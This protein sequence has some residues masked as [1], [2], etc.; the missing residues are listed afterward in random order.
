MLE[1]EKQ[2]RLDAD[3]KLAS[4]KQLIEKERLE[5]DGK[6]AEAEKEIARLNA[7]VKDAEERALDIQDEAKIIETAKLA[8]LIRFKGLDDKGVN[9]YIDWF[10]KLDCIATLEALATGS[11][12]N[13]S[14]LSTAESPNT[15]GQ[16]EDA[17]PGEKDK[18]AG[19]D[20]S[21]VS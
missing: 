17:A 5:K 2:T 9:C 4:E 18:V 1:R 6:I 12:P 13:D 21:V 11:K 16:L 3:N 8:Y 20:A 7:A 14:E 15:V 10:L 19:D